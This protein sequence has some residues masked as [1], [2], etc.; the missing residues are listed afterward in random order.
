MLLLLSDTPL[1]SLSASIAVRPQEHLTI[2]PLQVLFWLIY[3][4]TIG[5]FRLFILPFHFF[6]FIQYVPDLN[7]A[8]YLNDAD[9]QAKNTSIQY[10]FFLKTASVSGAF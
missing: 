7:V 6:Y 1:A 9:P 3:L 5:C 8:L 10:I 2:P 4:R